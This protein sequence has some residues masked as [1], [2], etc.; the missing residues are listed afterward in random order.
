MGACFFWRA[1]KVKPDSIFEA[2]IFGGLSAVV[3]SHLD[4]TQTD[5]K[6]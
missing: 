5:F 1:G 3:C 4:T 6:V 2:L